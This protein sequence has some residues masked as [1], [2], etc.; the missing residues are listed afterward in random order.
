[1]TE[2]RKSPRAEFSISCSASDWER[3]REVAGRRGVSINDHVI[4]AGLAVELDPAPQDA[5]ALAL[6]EAEQRRLLERVDRLADSM[7]A[8]AGQG[9][10]SIARLRQ[11]VGLV[12]A[13]TLRNMVRQGRGDEIGPLLAETF[14]PDDG[15]EV[16]RQVR[17][18]MARGPPP[19]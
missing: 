8:E 2:R 3:I 19:G 5:P 1:M 10:G 16:E 13:E 9:E 4:S 17:A 6:G 18:W 15:P 7:V 11:S 14:G 12:L